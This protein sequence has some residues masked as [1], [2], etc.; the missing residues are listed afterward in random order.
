VKQIA[1]FEDV[2]VEPPALPAG[3]PPVYVPKD[4]HEAMRQPAPGFER[5]LVSILRGLA[6]YAQAH[7]KRYLEPVDSDGYIGEEWAKIL[8]SAECLLNGESGRLDCGELSRQFNALRLSGGSEEGITEVL[9]ATAPPKAA[10]RAAKPAKVE[11][12]QIGAKRLTDRQR[13]LLNLVRVNDQ[14]VAIY[15][16][17]EHIPDWAALKSVMTAL[18]GKWQAKSGF[19]FP[20]DADAR[21]LVRLALETGEILDE[22]EAEF[23][24]TPM[25]LADEMAE[26]V[27]PFDGC[28]I[29]EPSAG[30]GALCQAIHRICPTAYIHCFE[31]M[32]S[33]QVQLARMA[34]VKAVGSDFMATT[35]PTLSW[36]DGVIMNPPFS[37]RQ[38]IRHITHALS[39]L[40]PGG[41]LAAIASAGVLYR[42]DRLGREFRDLL[43]AH[44]GTISKN[45]EGSFSAVGTNVSTVMVRMRRNDH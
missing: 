7:R 6:E 12:V 41:R 43:A 11:S 24:E 44:G 8:S 40:K 28:E 10:P 21:E 22:K 19:R 25:S 15:T 26:W 37:K 27:A 20:D 1:F 9:E 35:R 29:L 32:P 45:P 5:A 33:L 36:Y 38:D 23:F 30:R 13:D 4:H 14:N 18:G 39:F 42:D 3:P 34:M 17:Q 2:K 16:G 31:P